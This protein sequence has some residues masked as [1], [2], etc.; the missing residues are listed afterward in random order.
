MALRPQPLQGICSDCIRC[1]ALGKPNLGL[2]WRVISVTTDGVTVLPI[3][4]L[5]SHIRMIY[6]YALLREPSGQGRIA[7]IS[8]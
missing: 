3:I 7:K 4:T 1:R 6:F 2:G 8:I 5:T